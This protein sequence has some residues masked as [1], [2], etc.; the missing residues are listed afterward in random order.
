M[1]R[2]KRVVRYR[3]QGQ[4]I[5]IS[6]ARQKWLHQV[7]AFDLG[8][9]ERRG[10]VASISDTGDV[11]VTGLADQHIPLLMMSLGFMDRVLRLCQ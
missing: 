4:Q 3:L 7:V 9:G 6:Q 2:K 8:E 10:R 11:V 1:K 5:A